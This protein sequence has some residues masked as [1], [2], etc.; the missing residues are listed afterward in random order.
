MSTF[1]DLAGLLSRHGDNP[2][3]DRTLGDVLAMCL[4]LGTDHHH[5]G[6]VLLRFLNPVVP[7]GPNLC[8]E[9]VTVRGRTVS[10]RMIL[11]PDGSCPSP[12][13]HDSNEHLARA[14]RFFPAQ[15]NGHTA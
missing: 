6:L 9:P 4:D 15:Q 1:D 5:L 2:E 3:R 7:L 10:C 14:R 11:R 8:P 12:G 13:Y